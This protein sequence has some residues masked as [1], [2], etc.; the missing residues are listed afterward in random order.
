LTSHGFINRCDSRR[1]DTRLH[2]SRIFVTSEI[3]GSLEYEC[4]GHSSCTDKL[5]ILLS[6]PPSSPFS[7]SLS[8]FTRERPERVSANNKLDIS[9]QSLLIKFLRSLFENGPETLRAASY[10]EIEVRWNEADFGIRI[11]PCS[12]TTESAPRKWKA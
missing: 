1:A 9:V 12:E 3:Q 11:L 2:P 10:Y 8:L 6:L 7:L 4:E 5:V